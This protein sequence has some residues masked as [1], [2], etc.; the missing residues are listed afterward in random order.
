[1]KR[2]KLL[3]EL[4]MVR[5]EEAYNGWQENRFTQEEAARLLGVSE[6]TFRRYLVEYKEQ[7]LQGLVDLRWGQ[8]SHRK[9]AVDEIMAL[10]DLYKTKYLGWN[11]KHF[12]SFY[13]RKHE[14][15]RGYTWVKTTL[16]DA[17]LVPKLTKKGPH[18]K[19][20]ERAPAKGMMIH[21]DGSTHQWIEGE[22]WDL[23][24][25]F[26][27]ADSE[28]YSMFFVDEEG[29]HS[30]FR[31]VKETIEKQGLFCS[32][33]TD[34]GSHYWNTPEAGGP[35]DKAQYTQFRR[36]LNQLGIT[37][38]PAYSPEA[39]GRCERQF[40]THQGRLPNELA[41]LGIT[42]MSEANQ[43]LKEVY[44]PEFNN[45]FMVS[46]FSDKSAFVPWN[47]IMPIDDILCEQFER[48]AG[49]DNCISFENLKLQ[50]PKD[51]HRCHYMKAK[52][53]VH[54]YI[55]DELAIFHG[56]RKL[57][58]YDSKGKIKELGN[59]EKLFIAA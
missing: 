3:Q 30:S 46:P 48:V 59:E 5:F 36:G 20:R 9:A 27:D 38:I 52:V 40:R 24:I 21:Q 49:K 51:N 23:I 1:M 26:D 25:T 10:T 16:Q 6:R 18:R 29:T 34:R 44:M 55:N 47:N 50:I 45:E 15:T 19:R 39:R 8:I 56:P 28:H 57:A 11:V 32:F 37:M 17:G 4:L 31:G 54:R 14:G 43:Y 33:Y 7:G 22:M 53:R 35:V 2:T 42:K 13:C 12:F 41:A 58:D